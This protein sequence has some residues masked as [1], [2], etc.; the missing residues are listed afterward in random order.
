MNESV[1]TVQNLHKGFP[2][3][4]SLLAWARREPL[5]RVTAVD[6]VSIEV[7]RGHVLGIVGES[8]CG[9]TTLARCIVRLSEPDD[10][11]V[12][13]NGRALHTLGRGELRAARKQIQM[14]F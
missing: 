4:R 9:K 2:V 7:P 14:V 5:R 6:G 11:S 13:L 3:D 8:G 1:L 12:M 10:G